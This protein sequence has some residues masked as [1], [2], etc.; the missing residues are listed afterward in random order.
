MPG[1][2][3]IILKIEGVEGDCSV[4]GHEGQIDIMSS[5]W[6][7]SNPTSVVHGGGSGTSTGTIHDLSLVKRVDASSPE[8]FSK[9]MLGTHFD[10][11]TLF[12]RK[13]TGDTDLDYMQYEMTHV[14]ITSV[15]QSC[16]PDQHGMESVSLSYEKFKQIYTPQNTDGSPGS[17]KECGWDVLAAVKM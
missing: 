2:G 14:F 12:V 8:L 6:G 9:V 13:V 17:A 10:S 11:A 15:N 16:A 3:A 1:A 4:K 7:A 5:S